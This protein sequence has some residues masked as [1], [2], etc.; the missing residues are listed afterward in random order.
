M[1][2]MLYLHMAAHD[3]FI[4][5]NDVNVSS[6]LLL[7]CTAYSAPSADGVTCVNQLALAGAKPRDIARLHYALAR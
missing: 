7:H 3:I 4:P 6:Q 1:K 2:T 5:I